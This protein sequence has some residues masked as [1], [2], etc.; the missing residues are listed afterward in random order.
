MKSKC[1]SRQEFVIAGYVPSTVSKT[2]IGSLVLGA[3]EDGK[4]RHASYGGIREEG[5]R[6][7]QIERLA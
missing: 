6:A 7:G 3:Y 4:L 2:A 5:A 1:S